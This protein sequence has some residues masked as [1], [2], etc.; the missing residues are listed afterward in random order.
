MLTL[1]CESGCHIGTSLS[2]SFYYGMG[3]P[4][5]QYNL[6]Y[7][8]FRKFRSNLCSQYMYDCHKSIIFNQFQAQ[9]YPLSISFWIL[10]SRVSRCEFSKP[11]IWRRQFSWGLIGYKRPLVTAPSNQ[12]DWER[13]RISV[14]TN[15][16]SVLYLPNQF[17]TFQLFF[18]ILTFWS[19]FWWSWRIC[20][21][22]LLFKGGWAVLETLD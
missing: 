16:Q 10:M 21:L 5:Y 14:G 3:F 8:A 15:H 7:N 13:K 4:L 18:V 12:T 22:I 20:F 9:S 11:L 2:F 19:Q 17:K 1:F 6:S